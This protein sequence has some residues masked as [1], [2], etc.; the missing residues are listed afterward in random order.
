MQHFIS[1]YGYIGLFLIALLSSACIPVPSEVAFG[2][3]GGGFQRDDEM[4]G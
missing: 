3:A 4:E 1:Q 2:L